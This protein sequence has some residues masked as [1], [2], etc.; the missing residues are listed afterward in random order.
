M[1]F[2]RRNN[3]RRNN[4]KRKGG[5]RPKLAIAGAI[6]LAIGILLVHYVGVPTIYSE[7]KFDDNPT[8]FR[9]YL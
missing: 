9:D 5:V 4:Y 1:G 8:I 7:G 6:S 3:N 2:K